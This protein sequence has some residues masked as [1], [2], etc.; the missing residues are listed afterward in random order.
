M[1]TEKNTAGHFVTRFAP[2]PTGFLHKGH[3][4]AAMTAY[5]R[6]QKENGTF[7]LRIEDIDQTRC[8]SAFVNAIYEDLSWLGLTWPEP[9]RIQSEHYGDYKNALDQLE[10]LGLLYPCFCT[11]KDIQRELKAAQSAPHSMDG[12]VYPGTCKKLPNSE[13]KAKISAGRPYAIRLNL[14]RALSYIQEP[15]GWHDEIYNYT[16]A[17]PDILGDIV[18]AR[19]DVPTSYHLSVVVDDALQ[20]VSH[21]IRGDDLLHTTH[22]HVVL[23]KLLELPAPI[24]HHHSLLLDDKGE[25][26]AKRIGAP[27]IRDDR[28][29]GIT[30]QE[31]LKSIGF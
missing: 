4:F 24:Y 10:N 26:L 12:P 30:A 15:I 28:A 27:S 3:A 8:K 23:Q 21:I 6:A 14:K 7:L 16:S 13:I 17:S 1:V 2:S 19:K 31:Y 9:V 25:R 20:K 29:A 11:R 18:L 5:R 22:I